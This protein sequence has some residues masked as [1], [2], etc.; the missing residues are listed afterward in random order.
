MREE[1]EAEEI[2]VMFDWQPTSGVLDFDLGCPSHCNEVEVN[3]LCDPFVR[4]L[5]EHRIA[6]LTVLAPKAVA[7]RFP[8][9]P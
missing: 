3:N 1:D 6:D 2:G 4:T 5:C 8:E 9:P 7:A